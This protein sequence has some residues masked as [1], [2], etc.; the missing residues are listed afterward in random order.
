[1]VK[2][3][4]CRKCL[5]RRPLPPQGENAMTQ[6]KEIEQIASQMDWNDHGDES[7]DDEGLEI[8]RGAYIGGV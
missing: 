8:G 1:M 4:R 3:S 6:D 5:I 7:R 2:F